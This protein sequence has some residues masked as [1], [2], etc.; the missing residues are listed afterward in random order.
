MMIR[1]RGYLLLNPL[2]IGM[3]LDGFP[4][5]VGKTIIEA[6]TRKLLWLLSDTNKMF[7]VFYIKPIIKIFPEI[8]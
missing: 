3:F 2:R 4:V 8:S 6:I 5:V 1:N 7:I